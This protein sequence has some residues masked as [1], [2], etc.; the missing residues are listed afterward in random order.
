MAKKINDTR[1]LH[2]SV[3]LI[4]EVTA[5]N[6]WMAEHGHDIESIYTQLQR[7]AE[8]VDLSLKYGLAPIEQAALY[9]YTGFGADRMNKVL[10]HEVPFN[11]AIGK[12]ALVLNAALDKLPNHVG[13]VVRREKHYATVLDTYVVGAIVTR[14]GF[15]STTYGDE[16]VFADRPLRMVIISKTGKNV[17][18]ISYTKEF[19][20]DEEFEVLISP[21]RQFLIID[22][23]DMQEYIE[24]TM[25]EIER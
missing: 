19:E 2:E 6:M 17:H 18:W 4:D 12:A 5:V 8:I 14:Y 15:T 10:N 7:D 9:F 20:G 25:Q 24:I 21:P 1:L 23:Q 3:R 16:D 11:A 22:R 13:V